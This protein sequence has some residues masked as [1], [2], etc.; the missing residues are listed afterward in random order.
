MK[1]PKSSVDLNED[2]LSLVMEFL[3]PRELYKMANT[4]T[5]LRAAVTTRCVRE[6]VVSL[7]ISCVLRCSRLSCYRIVVRSAIMHGGNA[8]TTVS[9][10]YELLKNDAMHTPS[11]GRLL[12]LVNGKRCE[13]CNSRKVKHAN[14]RY[15]L[16]LCSS[17]LI[18]GAEK[19]TVKIT[20]ARFRKSLRFQHIVQDGR[21]AGR[22]TRMFNQNNFHVLARPFIQNGEPCGPRVTYM[23][24]ERIGSAT[25]PI[26]DMLNELLPEQD[27]SAFVET[28]EA[29]VEE[30]KAVEVYRKE[31]KAN[32]AK[33]AA[34]ARKASSLRV[35]AK[36][37]DLLEEPW[38]N[39][40]LEHQETGYKGKNP[41]LGFSY[42]YCNELLKEYVTSPSK[43]KKS[44]ITD[45]A[46]QINDACR[47]I[48]DSLLGFSF[49]SSE[50]D[51][52]EIALKRHCLDR[53][54][55]LKSVVRSEHANDRFV[56]SLGENNLFKSVQA[57]LGG[58][59]SVLVGTL[60][61]ISSPYF[62]HSNW[63]FAYDQN[64]AEACERKR[65]SKTFTACIEF[66]AALREYLKY[67]KAHAH[68]V[69]ATFDSNLYTYSL[70][71][72]G[73]NTKRRDLLLKRKFKAL[74][75]DGV[76][77]RRIFHVPDLDEPVR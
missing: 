74:L 58:D 52:F 47:N 68:E 28:Y 77:V 23:D 32:A 62:W 13:V 38:R 16:F 22:W 57:L 35:V 1:R 5:A 45:I 70:S 29:S 75:D 2:A 21:T 76:G 6:N 50:D 42:L 36:V 72:V 25:E 51:S 24:F 48:S 11:P 56:S 10:L 31:K 71:F 67:A 46:N 19:H 12:R 9:E 30:A 53:F 8:K 27:T 69:G 17:C 39:F 59:F 4:C 49:L 20:C 65:N 34:E 33:K 7:C 18:D 3:A 41:T 61:D 14:P 55:D 40:I 43:A 63:R 26:Q 37:Q 73:G 64:E 15:G 44:V 60:P 54:P 66:K